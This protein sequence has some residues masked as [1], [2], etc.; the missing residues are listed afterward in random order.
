VKLPF[1]PSVLAQA[2]GIAAL[3]DTEFLQ[4]SLEVN[5]SGLRTLAPALQSLGLTVVPSEA[6]FLL[7]PMENEARVNQIYT[8]LLHRGIIIRPLGPFGL[9]HCLRITVGTHEENEELVRG[10]AA[11]LANVSS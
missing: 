6:N 8:A 10:M 1:E 2:A 4:R 3:G 5:V 9:P 7:V 11:V